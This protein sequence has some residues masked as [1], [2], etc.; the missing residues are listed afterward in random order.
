[1]PGDGKSTV[2]L[3]LAT[4]CAEQGK[5]PVLV[6]EADFYRPSIT[7]CLGIRTCQGMAECLESDFDPWRALR[8]IEPLGWYLL[9]AGGPAKNPTELVQSERFALVIASLAAH[10]HLIL[11]DSPPANPVADIVALKERADGCLLVVRASQTP[12]EAVE[13]ALSN[14]GKERV[15]GMVLN[16]IESLDRRYSRHYEGYYDGRTASVHAK[17]TNG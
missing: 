6:I 3:N 2:V 7:G 13:E 10:F 9:P 5:R 1:M 17:S 15:V 8:R 11:I 14:L 4:V 12:R 16:G